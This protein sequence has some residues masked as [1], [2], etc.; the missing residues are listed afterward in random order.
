MDHCSHNAKLDVGM[1][2]HD[3]DF[4]CLCEEDGLNHIGSLLKSYATAK[5]I[6]NVKVRRFGC[7]TSSV[8]EP[9]VQSRTDQAGQ[10]LQIG[11]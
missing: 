9:C 10:L 2:V 1:A 7:E 3:D 5:I 4:V 11:T 6:A 8:V